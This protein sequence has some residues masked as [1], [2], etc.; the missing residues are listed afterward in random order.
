MSSEV[1]R[2][3]DLNPGEAFIS[4]E[5]IGGLVYKVTDQIDQFNTILCLDPIDSPFYEDDPSKNGHWHSP[6]EKVQRVQY[7]QAIDL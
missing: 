2:L 7:L 6:Y 3:K 5:E 1:T 4:L